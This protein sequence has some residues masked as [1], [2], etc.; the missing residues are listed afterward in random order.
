MTQVWFTS[1]IHAGHRKVAELRGFS[2]TEAHDEAVLHNLLAVTRPGD[3]LWILGDLSVGGDKPERW[4]LHLLKELAD[5]RRVLHLIPGNHD[6]IL[7]TRTD[8]WIRHA[9]Y[10]EVFTS[11]APYALKRIGGRKVW[12]SHFPYLGD[13]D[14]PGE[15]ERFP[16]A[17]VRDDGRF[18]LHGHL[19]TED[20]WTGPRSLHVG[21]DAHALMPV[22]IDWVHEQ[23]EDRAFQ[24]EEAV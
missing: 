18:L 9:T 16:E 10:R 5:C 13:G 11:F 6:S 12:L 23:V 3:H 19:H 17:R 22:S 14:R 8:S 24:L 21:L 4:A 2:N 1:D 20:I 7:S 15:E